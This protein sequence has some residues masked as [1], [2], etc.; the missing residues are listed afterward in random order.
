M[1]LIYLEIETDN[2]E[3]YNGLDV[4]N[5][6]IVTLQILPPSGKPIIIKDPK[7][8]DHIKP[9]LENNLV[10]G[11]NLK[12][13]AKFLKQQFGIT[14]RNVFDTQIAEIII[15]GGLY[16]GKKDVVRLQD[17]VLRYC[18][19]EMSKNEQKSF[20][21]GVPLTQAQ[22]EYAANDL[23]YLPEIFKQQ[24]AKIKSLG[25]E[26]I[27]NIEMKAIPAIV[28]LELSGISVD[29]NKL[30]ELEKKGKLSAVITQ[31]IDGLHQM[32]G[33]VRVLELHGSIYRNFCMKCKKAYGAEYIQASEGVPRCGC[34]GTVKPDV[35]LYE[36]ALDP[37]ILDE[38]VSEIKSAD[39][40]I[41]GGT[42]LSVWPAAGLADYYRG[43]RLVLI[44]KGSTRLDDE[45]DLVIRE[46]IGETLGSAVL[47]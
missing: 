17:L 21:Y 13:D 41:V 32:A 6:R 12:F 36:E 42:S 26:D 39:M 5:G 47:G 4:F 28:W 43:N 44:N 27:V 31:N 38:A 9:V 34:G 7:S 3:G 24:Q 2:S 11:H 16:A 33:S 37:Y 20:L 35:V 8:L 22:T 18:G 19:K 40:L 14:L 25:L 29:I 1:S 46:P 23:R 45:A 15:S 30:A 10:I